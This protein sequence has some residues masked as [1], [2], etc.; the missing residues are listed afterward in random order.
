MNPVRIT[1]SGPVRDRPMQRKS[2]DDALKQRGSLLIRLDRDMEW[3][4]ERPG[5][6]G[7]P[8]AFSDAAV[9]FCLMG[10]VLFGLPPR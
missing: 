4:A 3:L 2:H 6:P 8:P 10:K 7:R 1:K 9:Q 5:R